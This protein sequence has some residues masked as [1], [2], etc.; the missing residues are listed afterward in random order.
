MLERF[1]RF[2]QYME[3]AHRPSAPPATPPSPTLDYVGSPFATNI[4]QASTWQTHVGPTINNPEATDYALVQTP[5]GLTTML[6]S[7]ATAYT[8]W[9]ASVDVDFSV[10]PIHFFFEYT[11]V[12]DDPT[13]VMAQAIETDIKLTDGSSPTW[14]YDNSCQW[15]IAEN[16]ML[17]IG[18]PWIDTGVRM[19]NPPN[20]YTAIFIALEQIIDT[21]N[22]RSRIAS[23]YINRIQTV[24]PINWINA[25]QVGWHSNQVHIQL[26]QVNNTVVPGGYSVHF[27]SIALTQ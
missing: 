25:S 2:K 22:H 19:P 23:F 16:W 9:L 18:N 4:D 12:I 7:N 8:G 27:S 5:R 15:N 13:L 17:Q 10:L 1:K 24:L 6:F 3:Q 14:T 20:P 21:A 26:Q 11:M